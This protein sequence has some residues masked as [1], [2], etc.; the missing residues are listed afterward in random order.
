MQYKMYYM[1]M[2]VYNS[3]K[4]RK[5]NTRTYASIESKYIES[6]GENT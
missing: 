1:D 2:D 6:N 3:G 5:K 4:E